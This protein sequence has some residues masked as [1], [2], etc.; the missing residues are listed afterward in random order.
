MIQRRNVSKQPPVVTRYRAPPSSIKAQPA[1]LPQRSPNI[2]YAPSKNPGIGIFNK[3]SK[4][5]VEDESRSEASSLVDNNADD[6]RVYSFRSV[7]QERRKPKVLKIRKCIIGKK[8]NISVETGEFA[9]KFIDAD[10]SLSTWGTRHFRTGDDQLL[11]SIPKSN[12]NALGWISPPAL[13]TRWLQLDEKSKR[14]ELWISSRGLFHRNHLPSILVEF[15]HNSDDPEVAEG[16][17]ITEHSKRTLKNQGFQLENLKQWAGIVSIHDCNRR[18][19]I[20]LTSKPDLPL[21]M[22]EA[23]LAGGD[24]TQVRTLDN[25]I[26]HTF[27]RIQTITPWQGTNMN[28]RLLRTTN[29]QILCRLLYHS[30]NILPAALVTIAQMLT[31][32]VDALLGVSCPGKTKLNAYMHR[33]LCDLFN[34][35]LDQ[36]AIP[37]AKAPFRSMTY[38]WDAQKTILGWA[39]QFEPPLLLNQAGHRAVS[40]V[41]A[42]QKKSDKESRVSSLS[43]RTWPP[44][45]VEQDGMDA[46][47]VLDED[48]S[49]VVSSVMRMTESGYHQNPEDSSIRIL[50]GQEADGTPTVHTR[51]VRRNC[52][53]PDGMPFSLDDKLDWAARVE[54]TRDVQEAWGA[55]TKF[56]QLGGKPGMLMYFAMFEKLQYEKARLEFDHTSYGSMRRYLD[57]VPGEGKELLPPSNDNV[58]IFYRTQLQPPPKDELYDTM[59]SRD[60]IRPT[61]SFLRFLV[62]NARTPDTSIQYLQDSL[63]DSRAVEFLVEG[64][65]MDPTIRK[66]CLSEKLLAAFL[67]M[68]CRFVPRFNPIY[69]GQD[70]EDVVFSSQDDRPLDVLQLHVAPGKTINPLDHSMNLLKQTKPLF[71]PAWYAVFR[72]LAR[73]GTIIDK[74][75]M[76][77]PQNDLHAWRIME[78][79]VNDFHHQGL[80]LDPYGFLVICNGLEKAIL[81]SFNAS[82]KDRLVV[83]S[84]ALQRLAAEFEKITALSTVISIS[85]GPEPL[86]DVTAVHLHAY[87]RILGLVEDY[88]GILRVLEWMKDQ[89]QVLDER[90]HAHRN[91]YIMIRRTLIAMRVFTGGTKYRSQLEDILNSSGLWNGWPSEEEAEEYLERW[92]KLPDEQEYVLDELEAEQVLDGWEEPSDVETSRS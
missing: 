72:A 92:E 66:S 74:A 2:K 71:R 54:A 44:W 45:R 83:N 53:F 25:I 68:L 57:P 39:G 75:C 85:G 90:A 49:R 12:N 28:S 27:A 43:A 19:E 1:S 32:T 77:T 47:R 70:R 33:Q 16:K 42:A 18:V 34:L 60:G 78:A 52:F 13:L 69:R 3:K 59:I 64:T 58:S 80:E 86:H 22:L 37:A 81:A 24:I 56:E 50:G 30:R 31:P 29:I 36:L 41:L 6:V 17:E 46:Q 65:D 5:T 76:H 87:V 79:V 62:A 91:G 23:V 40:K 48:F 14:R 51:T 55:F 8:D 4:Q 67:Q 15:L 7:I 63:L 73:R 84:P 11:Q 9:P 89:H 10:S 21:F 82:N 35:M 61:G 26:A 20:F 88:E 38:A